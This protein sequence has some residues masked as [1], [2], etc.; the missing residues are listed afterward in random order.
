MARGKSHPAY[1]RSDYRYRQFH[2][3]REFTLDA[4]FL[5]SLCPS[6]VADCCA[7]FAAQSGGPP[8]TLMILPQVH[9]RKPCYDFYFL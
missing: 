6:R 4:H 3:V 2:R 8:G 1:L 9:L 7:R 5:V